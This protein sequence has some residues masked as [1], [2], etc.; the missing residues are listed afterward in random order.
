[1]SDNRNSVI[2]ETLAQL[3]DKKGF[4]YIS[5]RDLTQYS[6]YGKT[7]VVQAI[8]ELTLRGKIIKIPHEHSGKNQYQVI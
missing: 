5:Y 1:M 7:A 3:I 4:I 6:G 8:R 2:L